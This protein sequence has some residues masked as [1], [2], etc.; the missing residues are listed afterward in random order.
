[1]RFKQ[2]LNELANIEVGQA[3]DAHEPTEESSSSVLAPKV[4]A[5]INHRL[6]TELNDMI[7]SP[8]S[9]IQKVRK[10]LHRYGMDMP[11]LYEADPMGD[12]VVFDL[13]QFGEAQG[14]DIYGRFTTGTNVVNRNPDAYLYIVYYLENNGQYE[15]HAEVTNEEGLEEIIADEDEDEIE[16][17]I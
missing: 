6:I 12:E 17:E 15:F 13:Y 1:M 14:V 11:A 3:I 2:Y 10:V 7:L 4:F 8:E 9:G 16:I 5:E